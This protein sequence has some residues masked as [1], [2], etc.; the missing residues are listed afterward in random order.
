MKK[1]FA[2]FFFKI[3]FRSLLKFHALIFVQ[4]REFTRPGEIFFRPPG[5]TN[6]LTFH[7]SFLLLELLNVNPYKSL[8][9]Y[10]SSLW[11]HR[12]R[13]YFARK[14]CLSS[15]GSKKFISDNNHTHIFY[16]HHEKWFLKSKKKMEMRPT[17]WVFI[18]VH[19]AQR[20]HNYLHFFFSA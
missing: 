14:A 6:I 11:W 17:G 9:H 16:F 4:G 5:R 8:I 18:F 12:D 7:F 1:V 13:W 19:L 10:S 15:L 2:P 3:F 20:S